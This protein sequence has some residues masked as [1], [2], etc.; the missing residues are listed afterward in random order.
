VKTCLQ[1][2]S[3]QCLYWIK[4]YVQKKRNQ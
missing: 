4:W 1:Y 3:L 2:Y